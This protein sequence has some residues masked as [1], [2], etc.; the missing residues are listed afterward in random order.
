MFVVAASLLQRV[1]LLVSQVSL[2]GISLDH[3]HVFQDQRTAIS[4][5]I[6]SVVLFALAQ[7]LMGYT[8]RLVA[9]PLFSKHGLSGLV[10]IGE[11]FVIDIVKRHE[12]WP[13]VPF[14]V[15]QCCVR[16]G[17]VT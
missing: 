10:D 6:I 9:N 12:V 2:D 11:V 5:G 8:E 14:V 4:L 15:A 7:R 13:L 1:I 16:T 3:P 17:V